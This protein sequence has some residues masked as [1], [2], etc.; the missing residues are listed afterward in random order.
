MPIKDTA[1]SRLVNAVQTT[2]REQ[3]ADHYGSTLMNRMPEKE[4]KADLD[5]A[6]WDI[7]VALFKALVKSGY[8]S[9]TTLSDEEVRIAS[10]YG[11]EDVSR[12]QADDNRPRVQF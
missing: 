6:S 1:P 9:I 2:V 11:A 12:M 7:T 10:E 4:A 3:L 5:A 8:R